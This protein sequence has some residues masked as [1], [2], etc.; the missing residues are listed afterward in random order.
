MSVTLS[1]P[2]IG[3]SDFSVN[4]IAFSVG[5]ISVRWYGII[6][7]L[8]IILAFTYCSFRAK[9]EKIVFDDLLDIGIFTIIFAVIGARA[10]YVATTGDE[11]DSFMEVIAI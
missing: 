3:I 9:Q 10:Y 11:Y 8:G 4:P 6:I 7:T 1:F 5:N 2:G